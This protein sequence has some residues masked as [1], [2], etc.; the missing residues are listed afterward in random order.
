MARPGNVEQDSFPLAVFGNQDVPP[1][2]GFSAVSEKIA[3]DPDKSTTIYRRCDKLAAPSLLFYQGELAELEDIQ[4]KFDEQD[5]VEKDEI[6]IECQ[7]DWSELKKRA[8][9]GRARENARV[10]L[11]MEIRNNV[12]KYHAALVAHQV[13]LNSYSPS[14]S[15]TAAMR[16]WFYN[17]S[18]KTDKTGVSQLWEASEKIYDDIDDLVALNVP[19]DQNLLSK[20]VQNNFGLLFTT[21]RPENGQ[22]YVSH[23]QITR[24]VTIISTLLASVLLFGAIISLYIVK[25]QNALLSM[26]SGWTVLFAA[27]LG[28]LTNAKRN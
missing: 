6:S 15:T 28:L 5:R 13:L 11:V 21:S 9:E 27:Y 7:R 3:F 12:E 14:R 8:L 20:Y 17:T 4:D 19:P 2:R 10:E 16:K 23:R 18:E 24:A 1:L 26:V 25:N 22:A